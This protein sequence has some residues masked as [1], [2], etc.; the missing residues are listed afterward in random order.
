[1]N[2]LQIKDVVKAFDG[3]NVLEK[4]SAS[5]QEGEFVSFVGPSGC[6]KSTLLNLIASV[7]EATS[8][9]VIYND[10]LVQKQDIVSYMPQQDLLLPWRSAL[11]N[12]V[13]PLEIDGK[14][15]KERL[16]EGMEAL[17]QFGLA[18]YANHY[19][20]ALSGG[21]RQRISFLRTYLCE[22]PI[23][24]LDEPFGKLDAFTKMEVHRWLLDSWHQEKQTIVMVTHDLDEAILLSDRVFI[25]SQR[26]ATIVGEVHVNLPRPRTMDMLTSLEL[27][28]DKAEILGILAP[29]MRK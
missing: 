25:M 19:P 2:G 26:P 22:K 1:M 20:D 15:K 11:Q 18:E 8:G 23:M 13:L 21:M 3:K 28:E 4:I 10:T 17:Q 29:Y 14:P 24:L 12:I 16:T 5:I 6:G 7:E 9:E 27:K